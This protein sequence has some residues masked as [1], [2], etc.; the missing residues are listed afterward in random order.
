MLIVRATQGQEIKIESLENGPGL[1][2]FKLGQMRVVTH[3]HTF[4][5]YIDLNDIEEKIILVQTQLHEIVT[6][7]I[8]SSKTYSLHEVQV[9]HLAGK[10]N[11]TLN[12]LKSLEPKRVKRGL[13]DGLG[14]VIKSIT[15]NLDYT[16]AIKFNDA[17]STL[18]NNEGK[19][20]NEL[21][22]HISLSKEWMAK[23]SEIINQLVQNQ[24]KINETLHFLTIGQQQVLSS[25]IKYTKF[26]QLLMIISE[27]IDDL[28]SELF[29]IENMLSFIRA[30][31]THHSM[32]DIDVLGNIINN[33]KTI[34]DKE[35]ILDIDLREYYDIIKPG[36]FYVE[37]QIV[38]IFGFPIISPSIYFL[39]KLTI[40]PNKYNQ[41]LI[42]PYPMIAI[43]GNS[44]LYIEA[45][46][47]KLKSMY[48]CDNKLNYQVRTD[49]DCI[50]SLIDHKP[51]P[52][53]CKQTTLSLSKEAMERLDDRY[54]AVVFPKLTKVQLVCKRED[55]V[56][57]HGSYLVTI[58][59][60]CLLRTEEFTITNND[61]RIKGEPVKIM[62]YTSKIEDNNLSNITPKEI[63]KLN[64]IKLDA[65][66]EIHRKIQVQTP[67]QLNDEVN[68]AL[69]HTTIPFYG[70][71]IIVA[72]FGIFILIRQKKLFSYLCKK[73]KVV[74][75][76]V[77]ENEEND[78]SRQPPA[79]FSLNILK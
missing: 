39:F 6:Q 73:R 35:Q 14:S 42:P 64:T 52:K 38:I 61:D 40:I 78:N 49:P 26:G 2:P 5:Q 33:L 16:D 79:T 69:Y 51:L 65:L 32:I 50:K 29:R 58:P 34:Y 57:L 77:A 9:N 25:L 76:P 13:V 60:D 63:L 15:G 17:I 56:L 18:K 30:S 44:Y 43:D 68:P 12:Q 47:P 62:Q 3:Y 28:L 37:K 11:K 74:T 1:L 22:S 54:Y 19:I 66:H 53:F 10:L 59:R 75:Y 4:L 48:L 72:V 46:C 23:H 21:N 31:S 36:Y 20:S 55:R 70:L 71:L 27:N 41:T 24:V 45:E 67:V 8:S 7:L